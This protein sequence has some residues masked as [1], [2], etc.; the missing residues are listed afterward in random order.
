MA[1]N[2]PEQQRRLYEQQARERKTA[3]LS[4]HFR[5][6]G[7]TAHDLAAMHPEVRA[8]HAKLAGVNNPSDETWDMVI[9][10]VGTDY[11]KYIPDDPFEGLS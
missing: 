10:S 8:H 3:A 6:R 4:S 1:G 7:I 2:S 9:K 11:S 5:D